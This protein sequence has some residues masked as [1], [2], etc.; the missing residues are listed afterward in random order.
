MTSPLCYIWRKGK[1]RPIGMNFT[2]EHKELATDEDYDLAKSWYQQQSN[3]VDGGGISSHEDHGSLPATNP[4]D[5]V[6]QISNIDQGT[7]MTKTSGGYVR[8]SL[9]SDYEG[10]SGI[11]TRLSQ[12]SDARK[13]AAPSTFCTTVYQVNANSES[14]DSLYMPTCIN[15]HESGLRRS[16]RI[17]KQR[18]D[19]NGNSSKQKAH[20]AFGTVAKK[21]AWLGGVYALITTAQMPS[22]PLP[23][24]ASMSTKILNTFHECNELYDGTINQIHNYAFATE[25]ANNEV[26]TYTQAMRQDDRAEFIQ[27]MIK[28]VEDHEGRDHW[29][30]VLR[31][32]IPKGIKTIQA[33]WSF[34]RKRFPDGTLNKHKARLCAHGGMQQWGENYWETYSPVVNMLTVRLE[35]HPHYC[36]CTQT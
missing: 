1:S 26:F 9:V 35:T 22:H 15:L 17:K 28:E 2:N 12:N 18:Q 7:E 13:S 23:P 36:S 27:A 19:A 5:V 8:N 20:K 16:E 33:V 25:L 34:K 6:T 24:N 30:L 11:E 3:G 21:V 10:E 4:F 14:N 32:T 29:E 31:S